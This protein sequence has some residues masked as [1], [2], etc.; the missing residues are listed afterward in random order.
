MS[1]ELDLSGMKWWQ[2]IACVLVMFVVVVALFVF[3]MVGFG[4][5][6]EGIGQQQAEH[7]KCLRHATNGLEIKE[8]DK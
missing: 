8:C 3:A 6:I 7:D 1:G 5:L 2:R 4:I